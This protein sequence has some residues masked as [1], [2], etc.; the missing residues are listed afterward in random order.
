MEFEPLITVYIPTFNRSALVLRAVESVLNQSYSKV[1]VIVVDD[2]SSDDTVRIVEEL[3]SRDNRVR[4]FKNERSKGACGARNTAIEHA[5]G[6]FI[7]GLD[8]DDYFLPDRLD[9]FLTAWRSKNDSIEAISSCYLIK[10]KSGK[11]KKVGGRFPR[12]VKKYMLFHV[13]FIGNQLFTKTSLLRELGGFDEN[14]PMWQDL[15]FWMRVTTR[16]DCLRIQDAN[17]VIDVS[18]PHERISDK[19]SKVTNRARDN[20]VRKHKLGRID[21]KGLTLQKRSYRIVGKANLVIR[22]LHKLNIHFTLLANY[23]VHQ[24]RGAG[25]V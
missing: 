8:D 3:S 23:L 4:L 14:M 25:R 12:I 2:G 6:E 7:T 18:H 17:Y 1:E 5:R 21:L 16:T 15:D 22:V 13:N 11:T 24:V 19:K 9:K 10:K 20:I